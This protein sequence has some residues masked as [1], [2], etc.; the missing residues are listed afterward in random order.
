MSQLYQKGLYLEYF[1]VGYNILEAVVSILLGAIN[2]SIALIGFGLDSIVESLSGCILIWRLSQHQSLT[3]EAEAKIERQATQFVAITFFLMA[4]Y[5][6]FE[7]LRKLITQDIP[8]PSFL[9][10]LLAILSLIIMPL[11][12]WQKSKIGKQLNSKALIAD[13]KET[14]VCSFLSVALFLGLAGNYWFGFWQA[15]PFAGFIIVFYLI[16]E[17]WEIWEE[18]HESDVD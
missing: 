14:L 3:A 12:A 13:A 1:T 15:D 8:D 7:S 9:G 16:K 11:L 10:I 18:S 2:N 6:G 17:G 4:G 5:I